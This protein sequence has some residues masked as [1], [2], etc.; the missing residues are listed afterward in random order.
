MVKVRMMEERDNGVC[1]FELKNDEIK[2]ITSNLGCHILSIFTKD[3]NGNYGDVVLGFENVEDCHDDGSYM[4]AIVGRVAN[5]IAD[6]K[7]KLN[8]KTYQLAANNGP[9][10][11]HG[12]VEGFDQ[13]V[14]RY[15]LFEDGIRFIYLSPDM[16]EGYPGSLYLKV[17]Y[18]LCGNTLKMEYEA[19]SDRD[20]LINITNHSYFNLSA[21]EDQK[22]YHHQL[23]IKS[24]EIACCDE[25]CLATGK[26]LKVNQTPFDFKEFHEIGERINEEHEQLKLAGGYDHSFILKDEEDQLILYDKETGRK[27]TMTTTLPCIQV[28]TGNFLEGGCNGKEGKPYENRDGVALE[29]QFLPNSINIEEEPKVILRKGEQ[30]EAVTSYRFE[31]E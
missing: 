22:I 23:K 16:E 25:N 26:F 20:T 5:R 18:R 4:G 15:E 9:N 11:L 6:A 13:K 29:A 8:G 19:V 17:V 1:F 30:Y 14:F 31:V 27:L 3:R 10:S 28:Y 7:F 24:D 21:G 2:V 12:G